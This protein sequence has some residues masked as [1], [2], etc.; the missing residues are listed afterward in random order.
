MKDPKNFLADLEP[1]KYDV[2]ERSHA[3]RDTWQETARQ[4]CQNADYWRTRAEAAE[5]RLAEVEAE[6]EGT[7]G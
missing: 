2:I 3:D 5:A 4:F 7:D 1:P 6:R